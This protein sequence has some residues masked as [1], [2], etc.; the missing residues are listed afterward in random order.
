MKI[1]NDVTLHMGGGN[2]VRFLCVDDPETPELKMIGIDKTMIVGYAE[3]WEDSEEPE[4]IWY[5]EAPFN[6]KAL[7]ELQLYTSVDMSYFILNSV[8]KPLN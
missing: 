1:L 4:T 7:R 6:E 2:Y 3:N 5:I 8:G